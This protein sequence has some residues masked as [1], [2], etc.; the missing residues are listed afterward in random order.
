MIQYLAV[1]DQS[2]HR[3]APRPQLSYRQVQKLCSQIRS[4]LRKYIGE[5]MVIWLLV[6][7]GEYLS[8]RILDSPDPKLAPSSAC[9][10]VPNHQVGN[11]V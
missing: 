3:Q 1:L 2:H 11:K 10:L 9:G 4:A 7:N 5:Y 6:T 8:A